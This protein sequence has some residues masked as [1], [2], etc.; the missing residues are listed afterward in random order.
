MP[1]GKPTYP[2]DEWADGQVHAIAEGADFQTPLLT[3]KSTIYTRASRT[4]RTVVI[5]QRGTTLTFQF[6]PPAAP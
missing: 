4:G 3:M 6:S 1:G 5:R 2:W